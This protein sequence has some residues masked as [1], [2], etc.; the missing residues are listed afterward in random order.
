MSSSTSL[1]QLLLIFWWLGHTCPHLSTFASSYLLLNFA[2]LSHWL[3]MG[4][5][6]RSEDNLQEVFS[7]HHVGSGNWTKGRL[8]TYPAAL[9]T[10][11][12]TWK[13]H[14][15][16]QWHLRRN[17][18]QDQVKLCLSFL[19]CT[20]AGLE[21][22]HPSSNAALLITPCPV[23][24]ISHLSLSYISLCLRFTSASALPECPQSAVQAQLRSTTLHK[25]AIFSNFF[26]SQLWNE[27]KGLMQ[28]WAWWSLL[29]P[30]GR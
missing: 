17:I 3:I 24:S 18:Y 10:Q 2:F 4:C 19:L 16:T 5:P 7:F 27:H 28:R 22:T 13:I 15:H 29:S 30:K 9:L 23:I 11:S 1:F 12:A 21:L 26:W 20:T 6:Q 14:W 8:V 25:V